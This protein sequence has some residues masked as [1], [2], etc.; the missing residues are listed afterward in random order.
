M[1]TVIKRAGSENWFARFR[2]EGRDYTLSTGTSSKREA[3]EVMG[4]L[5]ADVR[6]TADATA[7]FEQLLRALAREEEK[8][9]TPER[10]KVLLSLRRSMAH[11]IEG[12]TSATLA[13]SKAWEAWQASPKKRTPG[14]VTIGG[15]DAT[16]RRF[17]A[18]AEKAGLKN[19]HEM[20]G[21]HAEDYAADLWASKVAPGTYNAHRNFLRGMFRVLA[22]RAG[23][24]SNPFDEI[25]TMPKNRE[26]RRMLT[27][28]EL[29]T[30][31][32][33]ATGSLR[34]MFAIGLY[35]GMRLADVV[36]LRWD[37]IRGNFIVLIPQKTK[38][39]KKE[40]RIPVH[41]VLAAILEELRRDTGG[42]EYLFPAERAGYKAD[43]AQLSGLIQSFFNEC[44]IET[45][46]DAPDK[47]RRRKIVRVGF[48][49]LR[50]SFVSLCAANHVPQSAIMELVGHGSPA[51]T[52][53]Y[54]HAGDATKAQAIAAL[55]AF[56]FDNGTE[57]AKA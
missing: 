26:S 7:L 15:Y 27:P 42:G 56:T 55:P 21:A 1:A 17:L 28:E 8:A 16:W 49:S 52:A 57:G 22:T 54:T 18:W 9:T 53:L 13:L 35:S 3:L 11:R 40:I 30:V 20:T 12:G 14:P 47:Q 23:L 37:A 48:H 2:H 45:L 43:R 5:V 39:L 19:L 10:R 36:S 33:R 41:P 38:R 50:H 6:G 29:A 25:P 51:M 32:R 46:E 4:R 24:T 31:C 44:G 34:Y